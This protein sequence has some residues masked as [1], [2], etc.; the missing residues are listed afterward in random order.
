MHFFSRRGRR[1]GSRADGEA[2]S[3]RRRGN[4]APLSVGPPRP[5]LPR[6]RPTDLGEVLFHVNELLGCGAPAA[7]RS[8][9]EIAAARLVPIGD[10]TQLPRPQPGCDGEGKR[11]ARLGTLWGRTGEGRHLMLGWLAFKTGR[12]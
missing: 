8:G 6:H 2:T 5:A 10:S 9:L 4:G 1:R 7:L 12:A 11:P 3:G